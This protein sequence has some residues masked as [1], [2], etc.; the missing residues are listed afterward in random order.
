M[1]GKVNEK[2][3]FAKGFGTISYDGAEAS[4]VAGTTSTSILSGIAEAS[5]IYSVADEGTPSYVGSAVP[6]LHAGMT[7]SAKIVLAHLIQDLGHRG[8]INVK[9][10]TDA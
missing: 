6:V 5:L 7:S 2:T 1:A 10:I 8:V 4:Y 9:G 3:N